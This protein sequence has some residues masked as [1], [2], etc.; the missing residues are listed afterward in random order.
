MRETGAK[1]LG[2]LRD[3]QRLEELRAYVAGRDLELLRLAWGGM[4]VRRLAEMLRV[5]PSTVTRRL[6]QVER[7][8][9]SR[10]VE[11]LAAGGR[12]LSER[13]RVIAL[14]HY[15]GGVSAQGFVE[16]FGMGRREVGRSLQQA[17]MWLREQMEGERYAA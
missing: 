13:D 12:W 17:K 10:E 4:Q 3:E 2:R 5:A 9:M 11:A 1:S 8:V 14:M 7:R 16:R 15:A 6:R